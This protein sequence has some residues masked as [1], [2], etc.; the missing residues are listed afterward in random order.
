MSVIELLKSSEIKINTD[1]INKLKNAVKNN[2]EK[3]EEVSEIL[4]T[5]PFLKDDISKRIETDNLFQP[6]RIV[7]T[8]VIQSISDFLN[9]QYKGNGIYENES[10]N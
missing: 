6:G 9:C 2:F 1:N 3:I 8:I 5:L 10:E 7:E 4:D